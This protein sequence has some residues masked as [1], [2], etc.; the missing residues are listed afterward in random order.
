MLEV[1]VEVEVEVDVDVD[2]DVE[3]KTREIL[4]SPHIKYFEVKLIAIHQESIQDNIL[5]R[6]E[7]SGYKLV[8]RIY[9]NLYETLY[10]IRLTMPEV[11]ITQS[12]FNQ[13]LC[14][15]NNDRQKLFI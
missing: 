6:T 1:E 5:L 11:I 8:V 12:Q 7:N 14:A 15:L 9:G 3:V 13:K 4:K 10:T 2:V